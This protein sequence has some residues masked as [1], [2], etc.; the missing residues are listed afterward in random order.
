MATHHDDA[1]DG[2]D[3]PDLVGYVLGEGDAGER[4]AWQA[5]IAR[6]LDVALEV[7][8]TR[9][10]FE[11]MRVLRV[12]PSGEF[13]RT[14]AREVE[15]RSRLRGVVVTPRRRVA[16]LLRV[17]AVA[18]IWLWIGER[19][20]RP[21]AQ[22]T[23]APIAHAEALRTAPRALEVARA[24]R[25]E[26]A[27]VG[28]SVEPPGVASAEFVA[29]WDRVTS[30]PLPHDFANWLS[31][32]NQLS[33]LRA[34]AQRRASPELRAR[35]R[36]RTGAADVEDRVAALAGEVES[37]TRA[38]LASPAPEVEDLAFALRALLAAGVDGPRLALVDA[39]RTELAVQVDALDAGRAAV[40][41]SALAELAVLETETLGPF[42]AA[43]VDVLAR[44]AIEA[45]IDGRRPPLLRWTESASR[46]AEA[47]RVLALAPAFGA[48]AP[49]A[50]HARMAI[51]AHLEERLARTRDFEVPELHA[52]LAYGFGDLVDLPEH[53]ARLEL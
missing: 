41:L 46:L 51:L 39:C 7:A 53:D 40:A 25:R 50:L 26:R 20:F 15:W 38:L 5:R 28:I 34:A 33:R 14:M 23:P 22:E 37:R 11:G 43:R 36:H 29:A 21:D 31:A 27:S 1:A 52:L 35:W 13:V 17:A 24:P 49:L 30:Q 42:V 45:P 32:E 4:A 18:A 6:D 19:S 8:E 9:A 48:D 10:L 2:A 44:Q 47:G 3:A 16:V 12:T